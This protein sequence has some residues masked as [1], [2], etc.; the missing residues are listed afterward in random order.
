VFSTFVKGCT[1]PLF[2]QAA[3]KKI[4]LLVILSISKYT[5]MTKSKNAFKCILRVHK[6]SVIIELEKNKGRSAKLQGDKKRHICRTLAK[7]CGEHCLM[8]QNG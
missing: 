2:R 4:I 6:A 7:D 8:D 1:A 5:K 3:A